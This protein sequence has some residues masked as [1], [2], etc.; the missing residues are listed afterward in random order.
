VGD[1]TLEEAAEQFYYGDLK[2]AESVLA[3]KY[4][5]LSENSLVEWFRTMILT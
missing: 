2:N 4:V 5:L 1:V 3:S